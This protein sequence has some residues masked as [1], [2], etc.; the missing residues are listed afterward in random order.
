MLGK[1]H[2]ATKRAA[3]LQRVCAS[4][5]GHPSQQPTEC[6]SAECPLFYARAAAKAEVEATEQNSLEVAKIWTRSGNQSGAVKIEEVID[7]L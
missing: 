7:I 1:T 3:D 6:D 2:L 5:G 4:C